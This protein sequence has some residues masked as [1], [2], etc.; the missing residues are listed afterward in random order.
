[1]ITALDHIQLPMPEGREDDARDFFGRLLALEEI[2]K[3]PSL[4]RRGGVWFA[5]PDGRQ[6][7][8]GVEEPF[9]PNQKA[10][11]AF[12]CAELDDLE[13]RLGELGHPVRWDRELA[14]RRRFYSEDP[15]GNRLEFLEPVSE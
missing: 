1:M 11:P 12:V 8:L 6:V 15:F 5:V 7:H 10:H 4:A 14:P 2:E 13:P 9:R 3:P